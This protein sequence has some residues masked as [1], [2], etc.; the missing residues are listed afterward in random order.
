MKWLLLVRHWESTKNRE[1]RFA[2]EVD[3]DH[4][5]EDG[6]IMAR[7]HAQSLQSFI[8]MSLC[9]SKPVVCC[10]STPRAQE[11]AEALCDRFKCKPIVDS[12]L[13]SIVVSGT[14]GMTRAE[15]RNV[16]RLSEWELHMYRAG[17]FDTYQMR[18]VGSITRAYETR[19]KTRLQHLIDMISTVGVVFAHRSTL[20]ASL[21]GI[22]RQCG[23][24]PGDFFGFVPMELGAVSLIEYTDEGVA[25]RV[26]F[27]SLDVHELTTVGQDLLKVM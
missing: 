7:D 1:D 22:A 25:A 15:L 26:V 23:Y 3:E 17:L 27:V 13:N 11:S 9:S 12:A 6:A 8:S 10:S 19:V 14:M 4:L 20:T 24:Y 16:D 2:T 5:T 18:H 21:I